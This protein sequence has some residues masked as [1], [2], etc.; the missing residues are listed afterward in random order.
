MQFGSRIVLTKQL[1]CPA[2][3]LAHEGHPGIVAIKQRLGTTEWWS[4]I[5]KEAEGVFEIYHGCQ[6]VS[7]PLKPEQMAPT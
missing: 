2:L 3:K 6:L 5:D 4:G 1:S 7:Q